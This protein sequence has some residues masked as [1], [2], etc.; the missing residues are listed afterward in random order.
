MRFKLPAPED[1]TD[2]EDYAF[3]L[4]KAYAN[5]YGDATM[6]LILIQLGLDALNSGE[7]SAREW[8]IEKMQKLI[9]KYKIE[10]S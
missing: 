2:I 7:E 3:K 10:E 8:T 5:L 4:A 6:M 1:Y 9:D